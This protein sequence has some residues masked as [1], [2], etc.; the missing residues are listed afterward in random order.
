MGKKE[1]LSAK[2]GSSSHS[3][4]DTPG[5]CRGHRRRRHHQLIGVAVIKNTTAEMARTRRDGW[6]RI[7]ISS[8]GVIFQLISTTS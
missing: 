5:I 2:L 8:S 1:D 7:D 3:C 4:C 6:D